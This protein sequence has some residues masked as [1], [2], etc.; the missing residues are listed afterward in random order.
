MGDNLTLR[1]LVPATLRLNASQSSGPSSAAF[2]ML[3]IKK[4]Y[5]TISRPFLF[6]VME[7]VGAG[8]G[9]LQWAKTLLADTKSTTD[10]N[11]FVSSPHPS[12]AGVRQGCP[13]S[14][15]LYLFVAWALSCW[16]HSCPAVGVEICPGV[17]IRGDQ[18][19]DDTMVLLKSLSPPDIRLFLAAMHTFALAS[20]QYIHPEKSSL[21]YVGAPPQPDAPAIPASVEGI[22]IRPIASSLGITLANDPDSPTPDMDWPTRLSNVEKRFAKLAKGNLSTFGRAASGFGYGTC[23]IMYHAEYSCLPPDAIN[24]ITGWARWFTDRGA[25]PSRRPRLPGIH[26]SRLIGAPKHGGL[27]HIPWRPHLLARWALLARRFIACEGGH[28]FLLI[29]GKHRRILSAVERDSTR[30]LTLEERL[31]LQVRPVVPLW[32]PLAAALLRAAAPQTPPAFTLLSAARGT[33]SDLACGRLP[34]GINVSSPALPEGPLRRMLLGLHALGRPSI[35]ARELP[36]AGPWCAA[37]PLW[38]N[39]ILELELPAPSRQVTWPISL[40]TDPPPPTIPSPPAIWAVGFSHLRTATLPRNWPSLNTLADAVDLLRRLTQ[41]LGSVTATPLVPHI[42]PLLTSLSALIS[43][44]PPSWV[45]WVSMPTLTLAHPSPDTATRSILPLL[46]WPNPKP[47]PYVAAPGPAQQRPPPLLLLSHPFSVRTATLSQL[48]LDLAAQRQCFVDFTSRALSLSTP[49]PPPSSPASLTHQL[50]RTVSSLWHVPCDPSV[51][52]TFWRLRLHGVWGAGGHDLAP[53]APC[54]CG[55]IPPSGLPASRALLLRDHCF[56][57]CPVAAAVVAELTRGLP[58]Q[59]PAAPPLSPQD[60]WLLTAPPGRTL[61]GGVWAFVCMVA[62][63]AMERGRRHLWTA[64]SLTPTLIGEASRT[65][66]AWFWLLLQEFVDLQA[67]PSAWRPA[68]IPPTHPFL[69]LVSIPP[70][71]GSEAAPTTVLQ[72]NLPPAFLLPAA[73]DI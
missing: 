24:T 32:I 23:S 15:L 52:D 44:F 34:T 36:P 37:I 30:H 49:L 8:G 46:G 33:P 43:V 16:L 42:L 18:Y 9:L 51:K 38:G 2:A 3:D 53:A 54:R 71:A 20:G 69:G 22:P 62:I 65:A 55:W 66:A 41:A 60:V 67:V 57:S 40:P 17:T 35:Q 27:G 6:A 10:V 63:H 28:H 47:P 73:L 45:T 31:L 11:G 4:A 50:S 72:L 64:S 5:D 13:L 19:A 26:T 48:R 68:L 39:P 29:S 1:Q 14:P 56:W 7:A 21:L 61:H 25:A 58:V 70:P 12:L 59:G